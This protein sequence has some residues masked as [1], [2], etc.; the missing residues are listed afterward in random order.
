MKWKSIINND[1]KKE[2]LKKIQDIAMVLLKNIDN[3]EAIG[4][5]DGKAGIVVFLNYYAKFL[6]TKKHSESA[7]DILAGIFDK[8]NDGF[9]FHTFCSGLGGIGW[10]VEHLTSENF[11]DDDFIK[12]LMEYLDYVSINSDGKTYDTKGM[13]RVINT[14]YE[15]FPAPFCA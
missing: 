14:F 9:T 8:I 6:D 13:D 4:I 5:L 15:V 7:Y 1:I 11:L 2:Y 12:P 10:G 3:T